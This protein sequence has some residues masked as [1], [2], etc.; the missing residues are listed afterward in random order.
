[1]GAL[2]GAVAAD[3][4]AG[5]A[6]TSASLLFLQWQNA[7]LNAELRSCQ[8]ALAATR[9]ELQ[10][11]VVKCQSVERKQIMLME[12]AEHL[13]LDLGFRAAMGGVPGLGLI[14]GSVA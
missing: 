3:G 10:V 9:A 11:Q 4:V 12:R 6:A 2:A 1:M 7:H 13:E 8:Q 14:S 5:G